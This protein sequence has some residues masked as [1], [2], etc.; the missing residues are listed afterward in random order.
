MS[1]CRK[2]ALDKILVI[3]VLMT[4]L[5]VRNIT[6]IVDQ[7]SNRSPVVMLLLKPTP[8]SEGLSQK[9]RRDNLQDSVLL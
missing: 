4:I 3:P 2:T 8:L 6:L 5:T 1:L 9:V 7:T